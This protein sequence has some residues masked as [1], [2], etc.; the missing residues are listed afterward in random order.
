MSWGHAVSDDLVSW[1]E[2]PVAIRQSVDADGQ[3]VEYVFSGSAVHDGDDL[4]AIYTS[5]RLSADPDD[6][7]RPDPA[8]R[9]QHRRRRDVG[10]GPRQPRA[11]PGLDGLP[12]PEGVPRRRPLGDGRRRGDRAEG[13]A[14][15]ERRPAHVDAAE[16]VRRPVLAGR[17]VG[18]PGPLPARGRGL[19]RGPVGAAGQRAGRRPRRRQRHA[20]VGG[21]LRRHGLHTRGQRLA[22]PRARLLRRRH[23]QRRARRPA[24][25]DRLAGQLGLRAPDPHRSAGAAP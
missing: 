3:P 9:P 22:G 23:L 14:L 6:V 2:R 16:R 15:R 25:D 11:R 17:P 13:R 19:R 1:D 20:V 4:V 7:P 12:R 8:P 5:V 24:G 10:Q 21:R 18:V